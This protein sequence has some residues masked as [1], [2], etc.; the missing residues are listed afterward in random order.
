[1]RRGP[2][3]RQGDLHVPP[4]SVRR[5]LAPA[6]PA[7]G[8]ARAA[9]PGRRRRRRRP[10]RRVHGRPAGMLVQRGGR[11]AEHDAAGGR[12]VGRRRGRPLGPAPLRGRPGSR[13]GAGRCDTRRRPARRI[14][15]RDTAGPR[16][17]RGGRRRNRARPA[18]AAGQRDA[19]DRARAGNAARRRQCGLFLDL[20]ALPARLG[21]PVHPAGRPGPPHPAG[22]RPDRSRHGVKDGR[23][24]G[25]PVVHGPHRRLRG[26]RL[27]GPARRVRGRRRGV[28][29]HAAARARRRHARR[30]PHSPCRHVERA[31]HARDPDIRRARRRS[32]QRDAPLADVRVLLPARGLAADGHGGARH[33]G[34]HGRRG[35]AARGRHGRPGRPAQRVRAAHALVC[36]GGGRR[37]RRRR[38]RS[39]APL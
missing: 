20:A 16:R 15:Q 4:Y 18:A 36:G 32:S 1:M 28:R 39:A 33:R 14:L 19:V 2:Q 8:P 21:H 5:R 23:R 10:R 24:P 25:V 13:P 38:R 6:R 31:R 17:R 3:R 29:R 26:R 30:R 7:R 9:R 27:A 34:V 35:V 11:A 37:R 12:R 22:A